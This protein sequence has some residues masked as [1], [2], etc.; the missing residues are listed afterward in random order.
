MQI[1]DR[2]FTCLSRTD[3]FEFYPIGDCHLGARNVAETPLRKHIKIIATTKNAYWIGGGDLVNAIKPSDIRFD[4]SILPEWI[5]AGDAKITEEKLSDIVGEEC[6]KVAELFSPIDTKCLGCL[7]GNHEYSVKKTY[8]ENIQKRICAHLGVK[9]LTDETMIRLRFKRGHAVRTVK[10]YLRHGYG[11]GRSPGAEPTKLQRMLD[12][13]ED[14]TI[15][16]QGHTHTHDILPAKPVMGLPDSGQ[17]PKELTQRYRYAANWGCWLY[18]H[19]IGSS[20]YESRACYPAKPMVTVKAV[21][22][23]FATK[24]MKGFNWEQ[25]HIELRAITL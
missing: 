4:V 19:A 21:I 17:L 12:E 13:W 10:L 1:I 8:N 25:P 22:R 14:A 9:D 15:C 6:K 23:P 16:F 3:E 7:E 11:S 5:L 2:E 18:S 20:T 24:A